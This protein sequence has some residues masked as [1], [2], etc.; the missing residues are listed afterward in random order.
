M[1]AA[2]AGHS[3]ACWYPVGTPENAEA[4]ERNLRDGLPQ[5]VAAME[6]AG[7]GTADAG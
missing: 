3:F 1:P 4:L 5:A 6:G 2:T 7:L